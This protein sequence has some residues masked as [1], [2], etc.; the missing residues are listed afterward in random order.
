MDAQQAIEAGQWVTARQAFEAMLEAEES[1]EAL[2]GLGIALW[3]LGETEASLRHWERA[4]AEFRRC[5]DPEQAVLA[6]FYLALAYR[7]SLGNDA[8]SRGWLGRAASLAE[9]LGLGPMNGWVLVARAYFATDT[10]HPRAGEVY[11]REA[12]AIARESGDADLELCAMSELG[13]ALVELGRVEEGT[14]L[15]D[16]AMAGALGG[17]G[18]DLDGIVLISCRT[19]TSCSRAGD[20]ARATQWVRAAD[21]FNQRYGSPHLYTTCRTQYGGILFATGDWEQAEKELQSALAIGRTAERA[22][23]AEVLANLAELR[24]AQGRI[25]EAARLLAGYEDHPAT[26]AALAAIHLARGEAAAAASILRR[27][28]RELEQESLAGAVLAELLGEAEIAQGAAAAAVTRAERLARLGAR[29]GS[30]PIIGRGER[31]LGRALVATGDVE[32]AIPHLE[33][34]LAAFARLDMRLDAARTRVLLARSLADRERE[35]SIAEARAAL[36]CFEDL[37]AARDADAAA[38]L[39]RAHGVKAARAGPKGLSLLTRR[40]LEILALLGEGLSNPD[41]A[42]RLFISRKTVEHHVASVLS[43]LSLG[44]RGE[45]TAYALRNLGEEPASATK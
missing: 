17:E 43:K 36:T 20:L 11:A 42:A 9:E 10:G 32:A 25:E 30:E 31:A 37:G 8:A 1:A 29:V 26:A 22:L 38:A 35:A 12:R 15:L 27:R 16:E 33:R 3:W 18:G 39:L 44:G 13:A 41:I 5:D 4:Y 23:Q 45:A 7:M 6:A 21:D 14:A 34:A 28:L 24:L 2:F 19:I 40:E